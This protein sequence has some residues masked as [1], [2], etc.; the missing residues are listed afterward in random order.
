MDLN[1]LGTADRV[2]AGSGLALL[3]F[4][5][6]TW[7]EASLGSTAVKSDSAWGFPIGIVGV[8]VGVAMLALAV[9]PAFGVDLPA[10]LTS[11]RT[12]LVLGSIAFVAIVL[13]VAF[14]NY[15]IEGVPDSSIDTSRKFGAFLG[16]IAAAGLLVG[17]IL[18]RREFKGAA[19]APPPP[20]VAPPAPPA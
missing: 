12:T 16:L 2:I 6:F 15:T 1:K 10:G 5:F 17:A 19:P 18:K 11:T 3:V 13:V 9:L 8:L 4:S 20:P 14:A 7:F